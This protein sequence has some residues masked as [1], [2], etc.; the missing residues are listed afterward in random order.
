VQSYGGSVAA[1]AVGNE[2]LAF[3]CGISVA[4]TINRA[5]YGTHTGPYG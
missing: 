4:P 5:Y 3:G 1:H 2:S